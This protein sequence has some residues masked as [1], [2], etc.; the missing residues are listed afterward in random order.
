M[1]LNGRQAL[2]LWGS[3]T[4]SDVDR[5]RTCRQLSLGL[6]K[7][8]LLLRLVRAWY[9]EWTRS[10]ACPWDKALCR[11]A[12]ARGEGISAFSKWSVFN[13]C[14]SWGHCIWSFAV[15]NKRGTPRHP[16]E[17]GVERLP[18]GQGGLSQCRCFW[19][20]SRNSLHFSVEAV[21][22]SARL[23]DIASQCCKKRRPRVLEWAIS[24]GCPWGGPVFGAAEREGD[25]VVDCFSPKFG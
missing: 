11:H 5:T 8:C 3:T 18:L 24:N 23:G 17:D 14:C 7:F 12:A 25:R 20:A 9:C 2:P 13:N 19:K 22:A 6:R 1:L 16:P 10:N 15:A 4:R 21:L